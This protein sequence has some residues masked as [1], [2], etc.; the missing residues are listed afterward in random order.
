MLE[1]SQNTGASA[2]RKGS[3]DRFVKRFTR[4]IEEPD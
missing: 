2:A 3:I 4:D 1:H